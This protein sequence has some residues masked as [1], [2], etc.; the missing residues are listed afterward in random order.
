ML[1]IT[2]LY[3][4][5]RGLDKNRLRGRLT[6]TYKNYVKSINI[7]PSAMNLFKWDY[8]ID[9]DS[10]Y[11]VGE[12]NSLTNTMNIIS[13]NYLFSNYDIQNLIIFS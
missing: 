13:K 9:T 8:I 3:L 2:I 4:S 1:G 11:I 6:A 5:Y 12:I 7:L 10:Y